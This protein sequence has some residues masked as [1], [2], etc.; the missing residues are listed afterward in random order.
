MRSGACV[1][2]RGE[3]ELRFLPLVSGDADVAVPLDVGLVGSMGDRRREFFRGIQM[4]SMGDKQ[5]GATDWLI[6]IQGARSRLEVMVEALRSQLGVRFEAVGGAA[7]SSP[8]YREV[9]AKMLQ[10]VYEDLQT[11]GRMDGQLEALKRCCDD[12]FEEG[13]D[14]YAAL[15]EDWYL[16]LVDTEDEDY[17][18]AC[19]TGGDELEEGQT[20]VDNALVADKIATNNNVVMQVWGKDIGIVSL[21]LSDNNIVNNNNN[22][23]N[24]NKNN[25]TNSN[26]D[27]GIMGA[28]NTAIVEH[29]TGASDEIE[30]PCT[31]DCDNYTGDNNEDTNNNNDNHINNIIDGGLVSVVGVPVFVYPSFFPPQAFLPCNS[32]DDLGGGRRGSLNGAPSRLEGCGGQPRVRWVREGVG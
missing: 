13:Q 24:N 16:H 11:D 31:P 28:D 15:E 27:A 8:P 6:F 10:I 5:R 17:S 25:N 22:N 29:D 32:V 1:G 12:I 9:M 26:Y 30:S 19:I 14:V 18:N 3:L 7:S 20:G 21:G 23:N 2:Q 4:A